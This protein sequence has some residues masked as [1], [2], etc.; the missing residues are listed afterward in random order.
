[1]FV[2]ISFRLAIEMLSQLHAHERVIFRMD[3]GFPIAIAVFGVLL[4]KPQDLLAAFGKE[5]LAGRYIP[6][7]YPI[8]AAFQ[9]ELPT[10]L[11]LAQ[12]RF[13]LFAPGDV[14]RDAADGIGF[15]PSIQ[16]RELAG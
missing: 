10:L 11:T 7:P 16:Q 14:G 2:F 13:R 5:Y 3:A 6:V 4:A 12:L 15:P 1:M 8:A 9:G